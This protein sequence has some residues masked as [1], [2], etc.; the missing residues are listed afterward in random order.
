MI[1]VSLFVRSSAMVLGLQCPYTKKKKR[2]IR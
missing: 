2:I 1:F